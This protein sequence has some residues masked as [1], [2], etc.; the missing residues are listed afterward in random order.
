MIDVGKGFMGTAREPVPVKLIASV[1][2]GES[3]P[4]RQ[5]IEALCELYGPVD[6]ESEWLPF[7]H[8]DYY[9]QEFGPNL[10]RK[11]VAFAR[12]VSATELPAIKGRTNQIEA[13]LACEELRRVNIDPGYVSLGKL[14]LASTKDHAHRLYLAQGIYGEVTL[15]FQQGRFRP[16]PWTYPDYGSDGYCAMFGKIRD[17][18]KAQLRAEKRL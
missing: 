11:I 16:W 17:Q 5:A 8:T 9:S 15:T 14:V 13:S 2:A 10:R 4:V 6:F 7:D 18:Y 12:L 3:G 1:L